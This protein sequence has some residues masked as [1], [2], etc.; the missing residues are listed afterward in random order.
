MDDTLPTRRDL[1]RRVPVLAILV[2]A[3]VT[4][5]AN[6]YYGTTAAS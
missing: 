1:G 2:A 6:S 4:G 3:C 5:C